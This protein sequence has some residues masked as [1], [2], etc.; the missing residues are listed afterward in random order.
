LIGALRIRA[1]GGRRVVERPNASRRSMM[2]NPWMKKNPFM[3][4]WLSAANSAAGS[5]RSRAT[6]QAKRQATAAMN[7]ATKDMVDAWA[8]M[9]TPLAPAPPKRR[10]RRVR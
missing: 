2:S 8:G 5:M 9:L 10:K 7:K 3:S 4:M 6:A 1:R